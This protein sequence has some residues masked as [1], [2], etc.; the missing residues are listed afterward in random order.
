MPSG[1]SAFV[2]VRIWHHSNTMHNLV[3]RFF[4][5]LSLLVIA[6]K[7]VAISRPVGG[8]SHVVRERRLRS[9]PFLGAGSAHGLLR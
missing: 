4:I 6:P 2:V 5:V 3:V 8:S 9:K 1:S 7:A